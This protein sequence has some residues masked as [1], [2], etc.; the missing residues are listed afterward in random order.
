MAGLVGIHPLRGPN[1]DDF[2]VRFPP[3]SDAY[4]LDLRRRAHKAWRKLGLDKQKR[5]L[6]EGI[7]AFVAGP[8]SVL[9][10]R[11]DLASTPL[12]VT[13][14]RDKSRMP[15]AARIWSRCGRHVHCS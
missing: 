7:Y 14:I 10:R 9:P 3:L 8:T 11:S 4:D 13:K 2:G 12:T 6:H 1:V 15:N 5:R